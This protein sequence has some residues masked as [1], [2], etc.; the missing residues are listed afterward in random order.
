MMM[1]SDIELQRIVQDEL[2]W[3]PS[4]DAANIGV[5]AKSGIVSLNGYVKSFAEKWT[6]EKAVQRVANVKAVTDELIVDLPGEHQRT[7][8]DI[9]R[10]AL[11]SLEWNSLVPRDVIKV[12]VDNGWI[13][14]DGEVEFFYQKEEAEYAVRNLLGVKGVVNTIRIKPL[15]RPSDIRNK[16]EKALERAAEL[17][18]KKI[19]VEAN[20]GNVIL[21]GKVRSWAERS[22]AEHAAW[23]APGVTNVENEI[24]ITEL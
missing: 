21:R 8:T 20:Q 14:L 19:S 9:A 17:D 7:D 22:E 23:A 1:P 24:R 16:I 11:N 13:T 15:V 18:A 12:L 4:I 6:A 3:D 5:T 10:A 2:A